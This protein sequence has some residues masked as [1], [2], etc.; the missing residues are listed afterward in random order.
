MGEKE[1]QP[2]KL[3]VLMVRPP[4]FLKEKCEA[5]DR[6]HGETMRGNEGV[7]DRGKY[8]AELLKNA[9]GNCDDSLVS[10]ELDEFSAVARKDLH[11]STSPLNSFHWPG[12]LDAGSCL[13]HF[14][15]EEEG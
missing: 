3:Q 14:L 8:H 2:E 13:A 7:R 10:G 11:A 9:E 1:A 4:A 6:P 5:T 15:G 12:E